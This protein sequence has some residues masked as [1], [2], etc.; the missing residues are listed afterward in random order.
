MGTEYDTDNCVRKLGIKCDMVNV[1]RDP[2]S[3][4][5]SIFNRIWRRE[6]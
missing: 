3:C 6:D 4:G 1:E 5:L 2:S